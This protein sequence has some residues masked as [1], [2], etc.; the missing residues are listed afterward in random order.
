M[1]GVLRNSVGVPGFQ[2]DDSVPDS[3]RIIRSNPVCGSFSSNARNCPDGCQDP[4]AWALAL[5]VSRC[6]SPVPSACCQYK[7][8]APPR[9]DANTIRRPSGVHTGCVSLLCSNVSLV[10]VSLADSYTQTSIC[11]PSET[12]IGSRG[13]SGEN[14]G[15]DQS[16]N[17]ALR[18]VAFPARSIIWSVV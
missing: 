18:I 16:P 13:P 6:T 9:A 2:P 11:L 12:S 1:N 3:G 7:L 15:I 14:R 8:V 10:A 5:S 17:A 4:G